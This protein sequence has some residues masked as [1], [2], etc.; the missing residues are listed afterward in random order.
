MFADPVSN[1]MLIVL[2]FFAGL[3][4]MFVFILRSLEMAAQNQNEAR[5]QLA[6][7]LTDIERKVAELSF[8][9]RDKGLIE[10][11][12]G[13]AAPEKAGPPVRQP[14]RDLTGLFDGF[15]GRTPEGPDGRKPADKR[16]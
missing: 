1:L 2:L 16:E 9:L 15:S 10:I 13:A 8:A 3:L 5:R 7:S 6:V 14:P 11:E 12:D 4:V